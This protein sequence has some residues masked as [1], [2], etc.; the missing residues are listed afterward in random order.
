MNFCKTKC[1]D[2]DFDNISENEKICLKNCMGKYLH[3]FRILNSFKDDFLGYF[4]I[5][6]FLSDNKQIE[7][8]NKFKG[9]VL[10]NI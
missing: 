3:Q 5:G 10:E 7:A 2:L 6:V 8:M 4:G 1:I 9:F